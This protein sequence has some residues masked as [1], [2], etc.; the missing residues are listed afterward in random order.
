MATTRGTMTYPLTLKIGLE[1][2]IEELQKAISDS[3]EDYSE[4]E[5]ELESGDDSVM[6]HGSYES[7][8]TMTHFPQTMYEPAEI[9]FECDYEPTE[10]EIFEN[11]ANYLGDKKLMDFISL[12]SVEVDDDGMD[13]QTDDYE[14]DPDM[15][16]GG[17][18][19]LK[20]HERE[21]SYESRGDWLEFGEN[22]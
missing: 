13:F 6:F 5:Y 3:I 9:D 15:M 16:P 18:D 8:C 22:D 7:P 4:S 11:I 17:L 10:Y 19:W 14:P 12:R 2:L 20:D 1:K 21:E